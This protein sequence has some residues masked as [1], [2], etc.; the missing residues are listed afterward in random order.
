MS[1]GIEADTK[2]SPLDGLDL[3]ASVTWLETEIQQE[4]DGAG[5][6]ALFDGNPLPFAPEFSAT[7]GIRQEWAIGDNRRA[8]IQAN[9]KAKSEY[10]LDAEGL[11]ARS[12]DGYATVDA[13]ATLYLDRRGIE[14]SL[15]GRN[16]SD[17]DVAISGYG[18]IGYNTFR[19]DPRQYGIAAKLSF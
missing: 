7:L 6:A 8:A 16:L 2:W 3:T 10:F 1:Y 13:S 14:L 15:W 5:N 4:S 11:D 17:E 12:Q 19:S 9:A 18:F